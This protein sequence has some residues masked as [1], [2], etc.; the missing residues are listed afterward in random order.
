MKKILNKKSV[1]RLI[2]SKSG[3]CL[4]LN[5]GKLPKKAVQNRGINGLPKPLVAIGKF[6][7]YLH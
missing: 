6:E 7:F 2:F 1:E 5:W 4:K 3:T